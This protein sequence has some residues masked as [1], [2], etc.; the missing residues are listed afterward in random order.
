MKAF[1][2]NRYSEEGFAY[3][4]EPNAY[5]KE[6]LSILAPTGKLLLPAEG[7]GRNAVFA[8]QLGW[9]VTAFDFSSAG[10]QK[11]ME[12]ARF[13]GVQI[14]YLVSGV[15]EVNFP[16]SNFDAMAL[17]Y[18]HFNGHSRA[19][20]HQKLLKM[21]KKGGTV[22]FEAY[23]KEQLSYQEKYGSGGPKDGA[24]LFSP[25]EVKNEFRGIQFEELQ[26]LEV[27]SQE[28]KYH[29]GLAAVIR[30]KGIKI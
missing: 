13:K 29:Q 27:N 28:G 7:E 6:K 20:Y 26:T 16:D 18:V 3:G 1:W 24:M 2:D 19:A 10:H 23:A 5:L 30:F 9:Q 22:I 17:I 12:L 8:A 15:E 4:S 21:V 14:N 25:E 11:A